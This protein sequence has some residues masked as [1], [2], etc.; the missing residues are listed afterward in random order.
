MRR[1]PASHHAESGTQRCA[2]MPPRWVEERGEPLRNA[3][4]LPYYMGCVPPSIRSLY[5]SH[6]RAGVTLRGH[7]DQ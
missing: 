4:S 5:V 2:Y 1:I 3:R 7:A 6:L